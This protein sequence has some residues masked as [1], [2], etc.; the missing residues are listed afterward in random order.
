MAAFDATKPC[1]SMYPGDIEILN[2]ATSLTGAVLS[3]AVAPCSSIGGNPQNLTIVN[4]SSVSLTVKVARD[5]VAADFEPLQGVV[6]PAAT[7]VAF[8]CTAPFVAVLPA[9]D[10]GSGEIAICR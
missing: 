2:S 5:Y 10:P 4:K 9:S 7:A 1:V 3:R 8:S 6:V